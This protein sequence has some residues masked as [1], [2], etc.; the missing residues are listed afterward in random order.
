MKV[1]RAARRSTT[2]YRDG[3]DVIPATRRGGGRSIVAV[4]TPDTW[5]ATVH[6]MTGLPLGVIAA[7]GMVSVG[8]VSAC[9]VLA[10]RGG[11]VLAA[12][13]GSVT[14]LQRA[15]FRA[16]LG[17]DI[18]VVISVPHEQSARAWLPAV[19]R[20]IGYHLLATPIG[21]VGFVVVGA[22]WSGGLALST[23]AGYTVMLPWHGMRS[24]LLIAL[25]TLLGVVLL[26]AAAHLARGLARLDTVIAMA[27]LGPNR[28]EEAAGRI[29]VLAD[30]RSPAIAAADAE[31]R[32]IER[33]L[34]DGTQ[35][36]LVSLAMN[37]GLARAELDERPEAAREAVLQAH[38]EAKEAIAELRGFV[39]GLRPAVLDGGL[40]AALSGL[41]ARSPLPVRLHVEMAQRCSPTV[42]AIAYF[43]VSE[44]LT[45][46][47][48]HARASRVEATV[49]RRSGRLRISVTDD[50]RGGATTSGTGL[51]GLAQRAES[52]GGTMRVRS[53]VGGPTEILVELPCEW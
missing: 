36:R 21:A 6:V 40:E 51:R 24:P 45:N 44:S 31:R 12:G 20:Q 16:L 39:R 34:H 38:D 52:I 32:R 26:F 4:F 49:I 3:V 10:A 28:A 19:C 48:R 23:M 7:A 18:P 8:A 33:D 2:P 30:D 25:L 46:V 29:R 17:V 42:E 53:P 11:A 22:A 13:I 50:G 5:L 14:G 27:L 41:A 1:A 47:T 37:L 35:Q 9:G 43:V 15:R